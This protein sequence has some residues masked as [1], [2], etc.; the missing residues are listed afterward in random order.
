M[1]KSV[2]VG[3]ISL[4][5]TSLLSAET[6]KQE[7][8]IKTS[9]TK[10]GERNAAFIGIDYQLG[11]LSTTA[12]NCSHGN[13]NGNQS[14]AYGSSTPNMPTAS[15]PTGGLT[16]GALGTRGYKGLS[17]QQYAI[18]GFGFVVGYKH[19]FKKSPQFGMRYYGF[20]DFASSY[21]KYY[22]YNDYG[23][24]DARKSSQSFMFGYGAGTDVL[25]NP[26]IF[27]RENLHFGFFL[28]VAI[29]GT[30]WGP[31]NYYFKDLAEEYRGS[32]H[33]SNFQ[34]LVNGGIRLGTKH[35][36]FEIG[37]KIQTIRNNYYTASADNVP[38]GTTYRFTFHRPYAF[39]WRYIVSF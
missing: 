15:N 24:R 5:M 29:G 11:M 27:N 28:G 30:S 17:N 38:E 23:M 9:P 26:A 32:F 10:K 1:K 14:G 7:K 25:F 16:H 2:I 18:N 8:A 31:T 36:G 34:V 39:Y 20:F 4:A 21:Y 33:P 12:Q 6:P 3:A 35:Q 13:C 22:T 19:F 37:L